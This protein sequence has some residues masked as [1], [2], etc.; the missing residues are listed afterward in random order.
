MMFGMSAS[1]MAQTAE[2]QH[3]SSFVESHV[4]SIPSV[5]T[6]DISRPARQQGSIET[7]TY[8]AHRRGKTM[9]KRAQVYVPYG[10]KAKD[11]KV[12]YDVLYLMHGGGDNTTSFLTPPRNWFALRDVLDHLI[13]EGRMRPILV[14]CPTFYDDD[15][16]IGA[17]RMEDATAMTREFHTELQNDLIPVVETK[18]NTY[19]KGTDSLAVTRSRDHRA[20]G[21]FSMGALTTW[22]QLA[23]GVNA[24]RT[25][26]PLSGDIWVYDAQ[27][28]KQ[29]ARTSA[30]W[31]N[32]MLEKSPFAHDFQVYGYTGTEDI[33]GNP[34]KAVVEALGQYAPL[35]RYRT[36]DANL[37]FAMRENGEHFYGHIN[38]YLYLALPVIFKP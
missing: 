4:A 13:E 8:T 24:V 18:Y 36:P 38:E 32:G 27:G 14:V 11:K 33:A 16:N 5:P 22:Y 3:V 19:L 26:I 28:K 21:G 23:Y 29:D 10:Y 34:M 9:T 31:I 37:Y 2:P 7:L 17:N 30:E 1:L 20:F 25:Y 15:Q 12:K 6:Q 35:F